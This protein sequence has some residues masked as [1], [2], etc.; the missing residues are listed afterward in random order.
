MAAY[1]QALLNVQLWGPT[2]F[3]PVIRHA[4]EI[5]AGN[6]QHYHVLLILTDGAISDLD[7][8]IRD[9][10]AVSAVEGST[11]ALL[12]GDSAAV[13]F[14]RGIRLSKAPLWILPR[15]TD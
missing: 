6:S 1:Q 15:W 14:C 12:L 9:V 4:A 3:S 11:P 7:D 13:G 8:T 5:A 10:V 2:N